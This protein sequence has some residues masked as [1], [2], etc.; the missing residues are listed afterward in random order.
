[1]F[2][3]TCTAVLALMIKSVLQHLTE[4]RCDMAT[5]WIIMQV[6][7]LALLFDF[8][9]QGFFVALAALELT[10]VQADI[11]LRDAPVSAS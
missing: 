11:R 6:S 9:R 3:H 10:L 1:M 2:V 7:P 8:L 5:W 4:T